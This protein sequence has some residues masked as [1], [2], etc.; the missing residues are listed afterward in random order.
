VIVQGT[1]KSTGTGGHI[2]GGLMA[3]QVDLDP[4][5][6]TGNSLAQ[7]SSCALERALR[8][9]ATAR[10]LGERAWMQVYSPN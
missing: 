5:T 2:F 6:L 4:S 9:S 10:P 8:A 7:F 1:V 3:A